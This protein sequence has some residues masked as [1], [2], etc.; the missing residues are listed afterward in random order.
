MRAHDVSNEHKA[1]EDV[2]LYSSHSNGGGG[3]GN[4]WDQIR[5]R[6]QQ[7]KTSGSNVFAPA[8]KCDVENATGLNDWKP[9]KWTRSG[10]LSSR[11]SG[12]SHLSSSKSGVGAI[13]P[14]EPKVESE[15]KN[16]TPIRSPSGD[17]NACVTSSAAASDETSS[18]KKPRLGWGEG[19]AKYE[20]KKVDGPDVPGCSK[21]VSGDVENCHPSSVDKS[22]RLM[23]SSDCGSP[24][25]P[26]SVACS[27]SP[28]T[29]VDFTY[30]GLLFLLIY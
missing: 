1:R 3:F 10:S 26:S 19:L 12:F 18:R 25:T 2:Q 30:C 4:T 24:A 16:V 29:F 23:S 6:D 7:D 22:P 13:E 20:K 27:S 28:G 9:I 15:T 5:P 17:A 11:G 21:D 14:S 8:H